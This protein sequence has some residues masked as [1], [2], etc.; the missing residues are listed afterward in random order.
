M[1]CSLNLA[2]RTYLFILTFRSVP[3]GALLFFGE[4]AVREVGEVIE[5]GRST[6]L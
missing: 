2:D 4:C 5:I 6:G 3:R 1:C